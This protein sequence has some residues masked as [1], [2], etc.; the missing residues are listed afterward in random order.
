MS[1]LIPAAKDYLQPPVCTYY[2]LARKRHHSI[3]RASYYTC[4]DPF[5]SDSFTILEEI[6]FSVGQTLNFISQL[7]SNL[8]IFVCL[9]FGTS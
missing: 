8:F 1:E 2:V 7:I 3:L 5:G 6:N 9:N 4:C